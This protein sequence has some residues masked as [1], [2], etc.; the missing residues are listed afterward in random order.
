ML[1]LNLLKVETTDGELY[2]EYQ[3]LGGAS[4]FLTQKSP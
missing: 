1:V 2:V 4:F 3:D